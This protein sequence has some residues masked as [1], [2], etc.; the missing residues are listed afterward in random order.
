MITLKTPGQLASMR[1][2]GKIAHD[3]LALGGE[4]V[5]PG[6]STKE[7]DRLMHE[8]ITAQD[9]IPTCLGYAGFP[10]AACISVNDVVIHGIPS[11]HIVLREGDIVSIDICATYEG[12]VGD[13]AAT[14]A[15]GSISPEARRLMEVTEA[16]LYKGIE[17]AVRGNRVGDISKAVQ[18]YVEA[19]GYAVVKA[20]TGHGVGAEMHEDPQVPNYFE[21]HCCNPRLVPGMTLT[22][23]PMVNA[24]GEG[25][26]IMKDGWTVRTKS[27]SL[28][29][30]YEHSLA[31]SE[32]GPVILTRA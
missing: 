16:S 18:E 26:R 27:G 14:F 30:H 29:A 6:V 15:V 10:A 8:Y 2:A 3:A 23:E 24:K 17:A 20:Y 13:T 22:I 32:D 19:A 7:L 21:A 31:I 11:E 9:A 1:R 28:A 25:I 5:R 4:N 12:Y